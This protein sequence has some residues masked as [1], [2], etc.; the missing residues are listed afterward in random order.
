MGAMLLS[1]WCESGQTCRVW[2]Y[3]AVALAVLQFSLAD[4]HVVTI[5]G[6][7]ILY[8]QFFKQFFTM[9]YLVLS[10]RERITPVASKVWPL[11]VLALMVF[12]P[13]TNFKL[14]GMLTYPYFE[15]KLDRTMYMSGAVIIVFMMESLGRGLNSRTEPLPD[16]VRTS[17]LVCYVFHPVAI[18][19]WI[20]MGVTSSASNAFCTA[21]IFLLM[22]WIQQRLA[23]HQ[24]Q[25]GSTDMEMVLP[26]N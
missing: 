12:A 14:A 25:R 22:A 8:F 1:A 10:T 4:F 5:D 2:Q 23:Q 20:T 18:V 13:S 6:G 24:L 19:A 15:R 11:C 7:V 26:N 17:A 3:V 9:G 21:A 16:W